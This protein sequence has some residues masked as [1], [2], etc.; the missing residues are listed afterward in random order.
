MRSPTARGPF[1]SLIFC[2]DLTLN[3]EDFFL[4]W[5][6]GGGWAVGGVGCPTV[7]F[8]K[9]LDNNMVYSLGIPIYIRNRNRYRKKVLQV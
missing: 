2:W 1:D 5:L 3:P 4:I 7:L 8:F 6:A 9:S